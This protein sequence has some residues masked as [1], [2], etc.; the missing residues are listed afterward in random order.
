MTP[1]QAQLLSFIESYTQ[2]HGASPSYQEMAAAIGAKSKSSISRLLSAL[3][4]RGRVS[5]RRHEYRSVEVLPGPTADNL[6]QLAVR[7]SKE[8]GVGRTAAMLH[9]IASC[10]VRG[11]AIK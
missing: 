11:E 9:D 1:R 3:H 4:A 7:L 2:R 8:Q 10:L 5:W 6:R